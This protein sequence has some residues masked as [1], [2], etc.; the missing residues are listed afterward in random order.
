MGGTGNAFLTAFGGD[1]RLGRLTLG[2]FGFGGT[3][4]EGGTGNATGIGPTNFDLTIPDQALSEALGFSG[5]LSIPVTVGVGT[6]TGGAG[7]GG[8]S[9]CALFGGTGGRR[10][11]R[12]RHAKPETA[13]V[14]ASA[15]LA[16][17]FGG[18]G[19]FAGA[20]TGERHRGLGRLQIALPFTA[21]VI[22]GVPS[23]STVP[24]G[25]FTGTVPQALAPAGSAH[26]AAAV[27]SAAAAVTAAQGNGKLKGIGGLGGPRRHRTV[28]HCSE[29]E[30]ATAVM[31]R[32]R[33]H[34]R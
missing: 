28:A 4:G 26:R 17:C 21:T 3:G 2:L 12:Q 1:G 10:R 30:A 29:G 22:I 25:T 20:G 5:K 23:Q 15:A 27:C 11:H 9:G 34:Q 13:V 19:G 32:H 16:P 31:R 6:G 14:A 18:T 7:G 33:N 8:G 24:I